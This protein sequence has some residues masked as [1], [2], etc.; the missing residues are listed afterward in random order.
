[1]LFLS[2]ALILA[3]F[4][5]SIPTALPAQSRVA[6]PLQ[7]GVPAASPSQQQVQ[8]WISELRELHQKLEVIQQRASQDPEIRAAQE[9]LGAEIKAA[10]DRSDPRLGRSVARL[11]TLEEQ[12]RTAQRTGDQERLRQ[13]TEEARVIQVRFLETQAAVFQQPA[14]A[15]KIRVF[16]ARLEA[17]MARIDAQSPAMMQRFRQLEDL[18]S[19]A[20]GTRE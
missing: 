4:A 19:A 3:A 13:I 6:T 2:R 17:R 10:M 9:T 12:A 8:T 7:Q 11:D 18:L 1:M 20:V 5:L 15:A 14:M 16:Q